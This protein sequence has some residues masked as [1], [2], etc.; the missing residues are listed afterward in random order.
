MNNKF[1]QAASEFIKMALDINEDLKDKLMTKTKEAAV[2][3]LNKEKYRIALQKAADAL[4]DSDFLTDEHEKRTF[5]RKAAED[6]IYVVRT[7]EKVCE[8]AD[9]AQI[10]RP[11]RIS[12]RPKEA[13][14]DP[15]MDA[16]FGINSTRN[17]IDD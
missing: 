4:Y 13:E 3:E 17:I 14:Y 12:A 5:L 6:P 15:V 8:A 1:L 9:V 7:L 11:A 2:E 10:G 16:A